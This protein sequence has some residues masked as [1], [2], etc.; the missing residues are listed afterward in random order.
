MVLGGILL[1]SVLRGPRGG[2]GL[3]GGSIGP[4]SFGGSGGRRGAGGRF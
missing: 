4:G 3:G 2:G 1:D